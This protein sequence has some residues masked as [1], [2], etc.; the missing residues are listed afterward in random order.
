[1]AFF[2]NDMYGPPM[3]LTESIFILLMGAAFIAGLIDSIA[4]G[5]GLIAMPAL[6]FA[7]LPPLTVLGTNKLQGL[8]GTAV[9]AW[10]YSRKGH[11]NLVKLW[12]VAALCP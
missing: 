6:L 2:I 1:M 8:F 3:E 10:S 9:A 7:G 12:P 4:G 11:V 5:G